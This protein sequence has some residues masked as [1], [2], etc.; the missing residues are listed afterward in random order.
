[1]A[2]HSRSHWEYVCNVVCVVCS[3]MQCYNLN[4]AQQE[5][6]CR[7]NY[8]SPNGDHQCCPLLR[9]RHYQQQMKRKANDVSRR[10]VPTPV[11]VPPGIAS[12]KSHAGETP[13]CL[14]CRLPFICTNKL[15]FSRTGLLGGSSTTHII[16]HYDY[17]KM[18]CHLP[19]PALGIV[20]RGNWS[21]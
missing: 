5:R 7:K 4:S 11:V 2:W 15:A 13:P 8:K 16:N 6:K 3:T 1:M 9:S 17:A 20:K 12:N 14:S 18:N 19:N 10:A 21:W